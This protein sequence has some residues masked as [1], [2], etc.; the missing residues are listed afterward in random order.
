M[1]A[2]LLLLAGCTDSTAAPDGPTDASRSS[3]ADGSR[4]P[5]PTRPVEA[6]S[7][8]DPAPETP[9]PQAERR[10]DELAGLIT[11]RSGGSIPA[12]GMFNGVQTRDGGRPSLGGGAD[13]TPGAYRVLV[14]CESGRLVVEVGDLRRA[15]VCSGALTEFSTCVRSAPVRVTVERGDRGR[16]QIPMAVGAEKI[17]GRCA[18]RTA[19]PSS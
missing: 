19:S 16:Q 3:S 2:G 1:V 9:S 13:D 18:A 5:V 8:T 14:A 15:V 10:A 12:F 17:S 6:T 4:I 7:T 11:A